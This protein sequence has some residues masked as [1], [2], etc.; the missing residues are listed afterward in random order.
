MQDP[1]RQTL[2]YLDGCPLVPCQARKTVLFFDVCLPVPAQ[3]L[4]RIQEASADVILL[5]LLVRRPVTITPSFH[6][7]TISRKIDASLAV[8]VPVPIAMV[9]AFILVV[10][11]PR[12]MDISLEGCLLAVEILASTQTPEGFLCVPLVLNR[13]VFADPGAAVV[14]R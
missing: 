13:V 8:R 12:I 11:D 2:G 14:L 6:Q 10:V 5:V 3:V 1:L 7:T 4:V 9:P